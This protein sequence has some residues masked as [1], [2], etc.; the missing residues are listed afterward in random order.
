MVSTTCVVVGWAGLAGLRVVG[1]TTTGG[2]AWLE[3][4]DVVDGVLNGV[5]D[6]GAVDS[7]GVIN[8]LLD[9]VAVRSWLEVVVP[10][11]GTGVT[12]ELS[13][14]GVLVGTLGLI[15][16]AVNPGAMLVEP[17]DLVEP[18][19]G[20]ELPDGTVGVRVLF[21]EGVGM[22][23]TLTEIVGKTPGKPEWL[24]EAPSEMLALS[25]ALSVGL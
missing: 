2:G 22:A 7:V 16:V 17:M 23:G 25:L 14:A 12:D 13:L 1:L 10:P 5:L 21:V 18:W 4:L 8:G 24:D 3:E 19:L 6:A 9:A 20:L 15:I 11:K